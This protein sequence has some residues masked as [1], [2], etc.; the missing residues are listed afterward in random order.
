MMSLVSTAL[1]FL[2][3]SGKLPVILCVGLV[4]AVGGLYLR[5]QWL[6]SD[7]SDLQAD[8]AGYQAQIK[9]KDTEIN[10]LTA[11]RNQTA[12]VVG[13][14][15]LQV[16]RLQKSGRKY[17]LQSAQLSEILRA[18]R[19]VPITNATGV[20]RDEDSRAAVDFLNGVFGVCEAGK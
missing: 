11:S 15:Q 2:G 19:N 13:G 20:V 9:T 12:R 18:S 8:I 6:K 17:R 4:V 3:G 7:I 5:V 14:L 16:E 10:L 1:S